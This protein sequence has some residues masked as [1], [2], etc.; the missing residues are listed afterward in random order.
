MPAQG[1]STFLRYLRAG[2]VTDAQLTAIQ[3]WP[4]AATGESPGSRRFALR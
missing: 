4:V 3:Q 1:V 2:A